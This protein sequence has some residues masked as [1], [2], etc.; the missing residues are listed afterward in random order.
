MVQWLSVRPHNTG[1][2]SSIPPCIAIKRNVAHWEEGNGKSAHKTH[3]P[4]KNSEPC[5]GFL[6]SSKVSMLNTIGKESNGIPPHEIHFPRK[7][8]EPCLWFLLSSKVSMLNTICK[9]SNGIPPHE[10]HIPREN[11][12]PY[13]WFLLRSKVNMQRSF[14]M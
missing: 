4:R 12:E 9:E 14:F 10:I 7:D 3:C 1:V 6:L 8:S 5:L 13:L 11:S 2:V